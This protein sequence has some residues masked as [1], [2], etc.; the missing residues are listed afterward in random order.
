MIKNPYANAGNTGNVNSSPGLGKSPGK[1]HGNPLQ[2]SC[3]KN[4][5]ARGAWWATVHGEPEEPG[6]LQS[7]GSQRSLAGYSPWGAR[8]TWQATYSPW[9]HKGWTVLSTHTQ[10]QVMACTRSKNKHKRER[11]RNGNSD[12]INIFPAF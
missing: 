4:P 10:Q 5:M 6:G 11:Q 1:G 9:G 2:Y 7:M 12:L 3:L 8:G